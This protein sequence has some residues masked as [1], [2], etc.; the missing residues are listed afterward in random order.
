MTRA[1]RKCGSVLLAFGTMFLWGCASEPRA[2]E[3]EQAVPASTQT[4]ALPEQA[5]LEDL[6]LA[7]R[8]LAREADILDA[9]GHV[10]AR[11]AVN[12]NHYYIARYLSPGGV[13]S[14]D[15]IENDL[16]S[17]PVHGPRNDQAREIYL[18]GEIFK[19]RPDVMAVVHAHT[20]EFVAFG[21]SS[22]PLWNGDT[23]APVWDIREFNK[24]RSGIVNTPE[25][26]H[27]MA[28]TLGSAE[29]VL[30][31]GHGIAMTGSSVKDAVTGV[32][33]LRDSAR[34]Q[35]AAISIGG[36]WKP[37][38]AKH[39]PVGRDRTWAYLR[40]A[41]TQDT[42]GRVPTSPPPDPAKPSDQ[43]EVTR[44]DLV[45]AN[46]ILASDELR[47]LDTLGHVS[48]RN[49]RDANAYFIAP[50]VAAGAVTARDV[51]QRNATTPDVDSQGL[52]IHD[53]V[54]KARPD[55][56]A[57]LYARTPEVV[58]FTEGTIK[59]RPVVNGGA[60]LADGLPVLNMSTLDPQQPVLANPALG[61]AVANALGKSPSVLLSGHG[62][63]LTA[64]SIY[65]LV[66]RAYALGLNA[67]IQQQAM[68][69]RGKVAYLNE[70]PVPPAPANA[71]GQ[72][73]P[74]GPP[75]G[76]AWIYWSQ[77]VLLD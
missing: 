71:A 7:N 72:N 42:G 30:L 62:F 33:E 73:A 1:T 16:D 70:R 20:P 56:M 63:V 66:D 32:I 9:Q 40:R 6:A 46:R 25:L 55:V 47:I 8:I 67:R 48:V 36:A 19:A 38:A 43:I 59:L 61:R 41:V 34:L 28:A 49:P 24:G 5:L 3:T 11:S 51:V 13:T 53:E 37:Q 17:K 60:F 68:A 58:A 26:G 15:F 39:D 4:P 2:S 64:G 27:A 76:R 23:K 54:Y 69:L 35:Q 44:R 18:H 75:E 77:N 21:M 14:S 10:T 31:W 29:G 12:P 65:N 57:V 74:L 45:L 50:G 52:S 22:V